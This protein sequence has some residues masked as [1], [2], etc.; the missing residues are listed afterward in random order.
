MWFKPPAMIMYVGEKSNSVNCYEITIKYIYF[1]EEARTRISSLVKIDTGLPVPLRNNH[2]VYRVTCYS[3][4]QEI[5][6]QLKRMKNYG[7]ITMSWS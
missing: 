1:L 6:D 4:Y 5:T 3:T 7:S 2:A